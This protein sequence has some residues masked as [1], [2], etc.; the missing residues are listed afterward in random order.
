MRGDLPWHQ[1]ELAARQA[2]G[3]GEREL[4]IHLMA[5]PRT[6]NTP[7]PFTLQKPGF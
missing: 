3:R 6:R 2:N 7:K 1:T 5:Q 4:A